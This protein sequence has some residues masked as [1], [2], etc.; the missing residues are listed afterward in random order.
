MI[1]IAFCFVCR[2]RT[3]AYAYAKDLSP[4]KSDFHAQQVCRALAENCNCLNKVTQSRAAEL[5]YHLRP[6]EFGPFARLGELSMGFIIWSPIM[7]TKAISD[8]VCMELKRKQ[9]KEFLELIGLETG[10]DAEIEAEV[11]K[12]MEFGKDDA[13]ESESKGKKTSE[14]KGTTEKKADGKA[15]S[16]SSAKKSKGAI[17]HS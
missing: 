9:Y 15:K 14:T 6:Q 4:F 3:L 2:T 12:N 10:T 17:K 7:I 1:S 13:A 5:K 16:G 11:K 8:K